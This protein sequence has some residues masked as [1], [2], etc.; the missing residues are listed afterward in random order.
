MTPGIWSVGNAAMPPAVARVFQAEASLRQLFARA[1]TPYSEFERVA[2]LLGEPA[3]DDARREV[4]RGRWS[5]HPDGYY[6][7]FFPS[8]YNETRIEVHVPQ[9][10][11]I[12]RSG[13]AADVS[14]GFR[15]ASRAIVPTVPAAGYGAG[16]AMQPS[17]G[18]AVRVDLSEIVAVPGARGRQRL[19]MSGREH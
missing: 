19:A 8:G 11:T 3:P 2:V 17:P 14:G 7:R 10:T 15:F 12:T 1:D 13:A 6:I 9:P 4:P 16:R 5:Y 18:G